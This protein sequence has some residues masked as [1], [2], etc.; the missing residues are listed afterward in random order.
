MLADNQKFTRLY[1]VKNIIYFKVDVPIWWFWLHRHNQL[2]RPPS[3]TL[4]AGPDQRQTSSAHNP[5]GGATVTL[6]SKWWPDLNSVV[7]EIRTCSVRLRVQALGDAVLLTESWAALCVTE[8]AHN[9]T[10]SSGLNQR[11]SDQ[12]SSSSSQR[13]RSLTFPPSAADVFIVSF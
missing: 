6:F 3:S 5:D 9:V 2:L 7:S 1:T 4:Y 12:P 8:H 11:Q 13:S 10:A